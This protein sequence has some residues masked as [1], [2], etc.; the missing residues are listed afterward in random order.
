MA[1]FLWRGLVDDVRTAIRNHNA[2]I[3]IPNLVEK[4]NKVL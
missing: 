1:L 2:Y 4:L 3:Y